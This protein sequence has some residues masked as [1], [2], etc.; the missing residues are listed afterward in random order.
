MKEEDRFLHDMSLI[1][2]FLLVFHQNSQLEAIQR[3]KRKQLLVAVFD[4]IIL[5]QL[6]PLEKVASL[7]ERHEIV[8]T[9]L[10]EA[11]PDTANHLPKLS[12][13]DASYARLTS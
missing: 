9:V 3:Q 1:C 10:G 5:N 11:I 4:L 6:V 7:D 2:R 13:R 12:R 8:D